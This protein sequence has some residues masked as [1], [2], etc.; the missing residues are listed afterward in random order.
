MVIGMVSGEERQFKLLQVYRPTFG[1]AGR[2]AIG[3]TFVYMM[4]YACLLY[5]SLSVI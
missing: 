5:T 3:K 4:L 2:L 1:Q